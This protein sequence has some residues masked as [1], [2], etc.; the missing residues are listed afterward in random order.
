M[1]GE[2]P[3]RARSAR[4]NSR[5]RPGLLRT[6]GTPSLC[7]YLT[8]PALCPPRPACSA[9]IVG[10]QND[11]IGAAGP[12]TLARP[13]RI[14]CCYWRRLCAGLAQFTERIQECENGWRLATQPQ[15]SVFAASWVDCVSPLLRLLG[16][17][18]M[19]V[20]LTAAQSTQSLIQLLYWYTRLHKLQKVSQS[21]MR[22]PPPHHPPQR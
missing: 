21:L 15:D 13:V 12:G 17:S 22:T 14:D 3:C 6:H 19:E 4:R 18:R 11:E 10:N 20:L 2:L 7:R 5:P 16:D 8:R 1:R 9:E